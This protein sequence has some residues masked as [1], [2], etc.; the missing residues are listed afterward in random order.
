MAAKSLGFQVI[1]NLPKIDPKDVFYMTLLHD[2]NI[3]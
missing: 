2:S 3:S 1:K